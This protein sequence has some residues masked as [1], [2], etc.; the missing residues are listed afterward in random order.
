MCSVPFRTGSVLMHSNFEKSH[1]RRF[2]NS[3]SHFLTI[4]SQAFIAFYNPL[5]GSKNQRLYY[6]AFPVSESG[7][8]LLFCK[9]WVRCSKW[10]GL[11][12][13]GW[14]SEKLNSW[15]YNFVEVS[16]HDL[17]SSQAWGFRIQYL[18]YK[19]VS[20]NFCSM[21]FNNSVSDL[22][23][24]CYSVSVRRFGSDLRYLDSD[25]GNRKKRDKK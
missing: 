1:F 7:Y 12:T 2:K 16:G 15:T 20:N 23:I 19:P 10:C 5:I 18:H 17:E 25:S 9:R 4:F 13:L 11:S 14:S 22:T 8:K 21:T 6:V 24:F 3:F